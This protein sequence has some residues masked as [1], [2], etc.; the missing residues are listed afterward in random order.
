MDDKTHAKAVADWLKTTD[1]TPD[2]IHTISAQS[3]Y[4]VYKKDHQHPLTRHQLSRVLRRLGILT[5]MQ[6]VTRGAKPV[7]V[8]YFKSDRTKCDACGGLG[9]I[10]NNQQ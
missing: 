6:R 10:H 9:F 8:Y 5:R 7:R 2:N 4:K 3:F 1:F